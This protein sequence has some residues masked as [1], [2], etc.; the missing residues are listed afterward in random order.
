MSLQMVRRLAAMKAKERLDL[1]RRVLGLFDAAEG[2]S[3]K[4][5][6][7]RRVNLTVINGGSAGHTL[8]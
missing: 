7:R 2:K 3:P 1:K 8:H 4:R 5:K 6:S